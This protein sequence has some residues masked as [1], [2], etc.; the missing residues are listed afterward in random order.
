MITMTNCVKSYE[1]H[2]VL[3]KVSLQIQKGSVYGLLGPNGI[4][5]TTM[6]NLLAGVYKPDLGDVLIDSKPIYNNLHVKNKMVYIPDSL[7]FF[8]NRTIKSLADY[9]QDMYERFDKLLYKELIAL[10]ELDEKKLLSK[11]SKGMKKQCVFIVSLCTIPEVFIIDE[12]VDGID[13]V[14]RR[15]IWSV[16]MKEVATREMTVV[17]ASHNIKELESVCSDIGIIKDGQLFEQINVE[18]I[19]ETKNTSMEEYVIKLMGG[20]SYEVL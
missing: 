20:E 19:R 12:L 14:K 8:G 15:L 3:N 2:L 18:E 1:K 6:L 16:L 10:F 11:F 17:L 7:Y 5:K 9:Y 13:P 4:G